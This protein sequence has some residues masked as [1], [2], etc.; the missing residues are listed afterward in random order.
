MPSHR[1]VPCI[2]Y[3]VFHSIP[4]T[5]C[6]RPQETLHSTDK[7]WVIRFAACLPQD[8]LISRE[9]GLLQQ[10]CLLRD[11]H[12]QIH[13]LNGLSRRSLHQVV[14]DCRKVTQLSHITLDTIAAYGST[15]CRGNNV[16]SNTAAALSCKKQPDR[17]TSLACKISWSV[18]C[19]W[20]Y[21]KRMQDI[22]AK[23]Y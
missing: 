17:F 16:I 12:D 2:E 4:A 19:L 22:T 9:H 5:N 18:L 6:S 15:T 21:T 7:C 14:N 10:S 11:A 23:P 3:V 1:C 20:V 8:M 13:I